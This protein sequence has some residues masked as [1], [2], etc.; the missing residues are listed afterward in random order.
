MIDAKSRIASS[1]IYRAHESSL[2]STQLWPQ[3]EQMEEAISRN[4]LVLVL[5]LLGDLVPEW[6]RAPIV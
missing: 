5:S 6:H 2:P 1:L 3:L 4:D